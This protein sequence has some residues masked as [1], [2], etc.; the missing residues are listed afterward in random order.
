M[1]EWTGDERPASREDLRGRRLREFAGQ[2]ARLGD[3]AIREWEAGGTGRRPPGEDSGRERSGPERGRPVSDVLGGR[4][5]A[6]GSDALVR[7]AEGLGIPRGGT[8]LG[9]GDSGQPGAP[10]RPPHAGPV[11]P[12]DREAADRP[13]E[14][15]AG[16]DASDA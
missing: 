6:G 8:G 11:H 5:V 10:A 2:L 7:T 14:S 3:S 12:E 1:N 13:G 9:S 4:R 15:C 16:S